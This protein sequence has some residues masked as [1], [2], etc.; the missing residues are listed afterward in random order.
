[1]LSLIKNELMKIFKRK[2]IY[3]LFILAIV[4]ISIYSIFS[5][6]LSQNV[7]IKEQYEKVYNNDTLLLE[8]YETL[9]ISEP[10]EDIEERIALEK[11]AIENKIEY[12]I[13]LNSQN[14]N[15][16]LPKDARYLIMKIFDNFDIAIIFIII[17][18]SSTIIV[19][20]YNTGTIKNLLTKPYKRIAILISK[21]TT[22]LGVTTLIVISIIAL[23]YLIGGLLF[24]FNSYGLEAIRYNPITKDIVTMNLNEY[25]IILILSKMPMYIL[26]TLASLLFGVVTNNIALNILISLGLY[27]ISTFEILVNNISKFLF[28]FNWDISK[29]IFTDLKIPILI[30]FVS[31]IFITIILIYIFNNKDIRSE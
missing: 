16:S 13:L 30:S 26:L 23:Q 24:G 27:I 1:M 21:I 15:I 29:Y 31:A 12:N 4:F 7:N 20:E 25:M 19:E 8:N 5:K 22:S 2:N 11:Y 9:N 17:Y 14:K 18:L 6:L 28:I 3:V 10:Y